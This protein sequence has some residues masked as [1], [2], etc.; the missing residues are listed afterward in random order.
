[1]SNLVYVYLVVLSRSYEFLSSF[2]LVRILTNTLCDGDNINLVS[3]ILY[4]AQYDQWNWSFPYHESLVLLLE[5]GDGKLSSVEV[6]A[7]L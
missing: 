6:G 3:S 2:E 7:A 4:F 1:M 5:T